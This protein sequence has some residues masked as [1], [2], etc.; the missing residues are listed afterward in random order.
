[1]ER[2]LR[3]IYDLLHEDEKRGAKQIKAGNVE[4]WQLSDGQVFRFRPFGGSKGKA[5]QDFIRLRHM[6]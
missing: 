1:M 6:M 3:N 2:N 5:E 4:E